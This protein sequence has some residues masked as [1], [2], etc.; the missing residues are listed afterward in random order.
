[1]IRRYAT[2]FSL[3]ALAAASETG[4]GKTPVKND[5]PVPE[6]DTQNKSETQLQQN[7]AAAQTVSLDAV[8]KMIND[9][10]A[11]KQADFDKALLQQQKDTQIAIDAQKKDADDRIAE[12][13]QAN[14]ALRQTVADLHEELEAS[15]DPSDPQA[16]RSKPNSAPN[17]LETT[18]DENGKPKTFMGKPVVH[19]SQLPGYKGLADESGRPIVDEADAEEA[20]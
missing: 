14:T 17:V 1:M 7:A 9:A 3:V 12:I 2:L 6:T 5:A 4:S 20:A 11:A 8:Q 13:T 19:I 16:P 10:L 18:Y 15:S